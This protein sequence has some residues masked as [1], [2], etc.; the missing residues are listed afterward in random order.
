VTFVVSADWLDD[1]GI[2]PEEIRLMRYVDG[3][4]QSL[5]TEFI[6]EVSGGYRFRAITPGFSTFAIAAAGTENVSA[7]TEATNSPTE[8]ETNVT[9]TVTAETTTVATTAPAATTPAEAPLIYAPL[10][11]PLAFLLWP[12]KRA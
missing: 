7:T 8:K 11:A 5:E 10:L 3:A 2:V 12:R 9:E 6:D 1:H 4:W